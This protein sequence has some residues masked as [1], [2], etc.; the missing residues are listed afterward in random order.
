MKYLFMVCNTEFQLYLE[1]VLNSFA[2]NPYFLKNC[3]P[4]NFERGSVKIY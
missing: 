4:Y 1:K 3:G 2:I